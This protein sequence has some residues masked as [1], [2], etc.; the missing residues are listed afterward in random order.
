MFI[1]IFIGIGFAVTEQISIS[2]ILRA[3]MVFWL[4]M[5]LCLVSQSLVNANAYITQ[6]KWHAS[7]CDSR[8]F[9]WIS[10]LSFSHEPVC[11]NHMSFS[12]VSPPPSYLSNSPLPYL[13]LSFLHHPLTH[14]PPPSMILRTEQRWRVFRFKTPR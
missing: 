3:S 6:I 7:I 1:S 13:Q 9:Q 14:A 4:I 12:S 2:G 11:N 5:Q 10:H 8:C